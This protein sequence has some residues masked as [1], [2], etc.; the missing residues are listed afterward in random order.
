MRPETLKLV[1]ERAGNTLGLIDTGNDFLNRTQMAQ[2]LRERIDKW[3]NMKLK[4]SAQQKERSPNR[5][6][7]PQNGRKSLPAIYLT[8]D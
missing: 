3:D 4:T 7:C 1:R 8:R 6:G 5:R 2:Q